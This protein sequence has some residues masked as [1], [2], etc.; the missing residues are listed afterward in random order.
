MPNLLQAIKNKMTRTKMVCAKCSRAQG[1]VTKDIFHTGIT[2]ETVVNDVGEVAQGV[3]TINLCHSC[4]ERNDWHNCTQCARL[5]TANSHV[6]NEDEECLC[7]DCS[8]EQ[9]FCCAECYC[10]FFN[11]EENYDE[12]RD[13][14]YCN[15]CWEEYQN[16]GS[17]I[18]NNDRKEWFK[19]AAYE[20]DAQ[21]G[22]IVTASTTRKAGVEIECYYPN[23]TARGT[24]IRAVPDGVGYYGDGSLNE[25]GIEIP[26]PPAAGHH[27]EDI[28]IKVSKLLKANKFKV[29]ERCGAHI[30]LS[31]DDMN[32]EQIINALDWYLNFEDVL[33]CMVP[34]QRR[35][36]KF[37][38]SIRRK[39]VPAQFTELK[40]NDSFKR[41]T[42]DR[43]KSAVSDRWH[44]NGAKFNGVNFGYHFHEGHIEVR[45]HSGTIESKKI[46]EWIQVHMSILE[47]A[48]TK[49]PDMGD[50]EGLT[51]AQKCVY[52]L[53][54]LG[55]SESSREY[56]RKRIL[57]LSGFDIDAVDMPK[58]KVAVVSALTPAM[59]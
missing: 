13:R 40:S 36:N 30:H 12:D 34:S 3:R 22:K 9:T 14:C 59:A 11:R 6:H 2:V 41:F 29:D 56:W 51:V 45:Y 7:D 8:N 18:H 27:L 52:L 48:L 5:S 17:T 16:N 57:K 1:D 15:D 10:T 4:W 42:E 49:S 26:T 54:V 55:L 28:I 53:R 33:F 23:L 38:C 35:N 32:S 24:V 47:M 50:V 31:T 25:Q 46:L 37:C 58:A 39:Y 19:V 20:K 44:T 21:R 43:K